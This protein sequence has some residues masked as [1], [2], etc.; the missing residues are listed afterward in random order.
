MQ[1]L[2]L[3]DMRKVVVLAF[4][5]LSLLQFIQ[6]LLVVSNKLC[7]AALVSEKHL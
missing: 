4:D 2:C 3:F 6:S 7:V 1:N 5:C